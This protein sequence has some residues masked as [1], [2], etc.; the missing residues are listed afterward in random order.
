MSLA[1]LDGLEIADCDALL[2]ELGEH[3]SQF[4]QL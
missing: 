3:L 4:N 1:L 2:V